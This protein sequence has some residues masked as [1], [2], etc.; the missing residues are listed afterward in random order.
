[1]NKDEIIKNIVSE[2]GKISPEMISEHS[3]FVNDVHRFVE[4]LVSVHEHC[5]KREN[6][7]YCISMNYSFTESVEMK[8]LNQ[9]YAHSKNCA[10]KEELH[11]FITVLMSSRNPG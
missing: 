9:I 11:N 6:Y 1:M 3:V 2:I 7:S 10:T 8:L 4:H 5:Q